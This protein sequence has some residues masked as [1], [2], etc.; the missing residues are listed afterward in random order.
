[1]GLGIFQPGCDCCEPC[2]EW[3]GEPP[4]EIQVTLPATC[5]RAGAY[6]LPRQDGHIYTGDC[7][8]SPTISVPVL[9]P[10]YWEEF[11][12]G[13]DRDTIAVTFGQD[14]GGQAVVVVS[15]CNNNGCLADGTDVG[16]LWGGGI[17]G[18]DEWSD[19]DGMSL[20]WANRAACSAPSNEGLTYCADT[21][22]D[23]IIDFLP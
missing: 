21:V 20:A 9:C 22:G 23:A 14:A 8:N 19:L 1:M 5:E 4:D 11:G 18:I 13:N 12:S 16:T 10:T 2:S 15:V 17:A 3:L 7:H 6:T